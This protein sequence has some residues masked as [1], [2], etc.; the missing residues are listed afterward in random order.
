MG[1]KLVVSKPKVIQM[2]N[3]KTKKEQEFIKQKVIQRST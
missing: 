1:E 2:K 3:L